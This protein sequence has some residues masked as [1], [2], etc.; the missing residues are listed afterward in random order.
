MVPEY[1]CCGPNILSADGEYRS[2]FTSVRMLQYINIHFKSLMEETEEYLQSKTKLKF[3]QQYYL[4]PNSDGDLF[5]NIIKNSRLNIQLFVVSWLVNGILMFQNLQSKNIHT[6]YQLTMY[7]NKDNE[8]MGYLFKTYSKNVMRDVYTV[9]TLS[10]SSQTNQKSVSDILNSNIRL[11]QKIIPL[12]KDGVDTLNIQYNTWR[13]IYI[14]MLCNDLLANII[15]PGVPLLYNWIIINGV[16]KYIFNNPDIKKQMVLENEEYMNSEYLTN[17]SNIINK[18]DKAVMVLTEYTGRTVNDIKLLVDSDE[19][20]S[21]VGNMFKNSVSFKKY[22]F[23]IVYTLLCLHQKLNI[24][25]GDL[26]L[27]NVTIRHTYKNYLKNVKSGNGKNI[28][29]VDDNIYEFDTM[30]FDGTVIDFSRSF[31]ISSNPK[32]QEEQIEKIL[33]Y[34]LTLF[35][36]FYKKYEKELKLKL[37][38][39]FMSV[40]M[41]FASIDLYIHTKCLLQFISNNKKLNTTKL[42]LQLVLDLNSLSIK[43]LTVDIIQVLSGKKIHSYKC[44]EF[45]KYFKN[46]KSDE[47]VENIYNFNNELTYSYNS[48]NKLPIMLKYLKMK[49]H[50]DDTEIFMPLR[51]DV[52]QDKLNVHF[53]NKNNYIITA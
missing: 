18:S 41:I 1:I 3:Y 27:N 40:Y 31:L 38:N 15:C 8:F 49:K 2:N 19:Y 23:D 43:H 28:F 45:L 42:N 46:C 17:R 16:D 5:K 36:D 6:D 30:G 34:Y 21:S 50:G 14:G 12:N 10:H 52:H 29:I 7:D 53:I 39:D 51:N 24:I 37:V 22:I 20:I 33:H 11:G 4:L 35:P 9:A 47:T 44:K 32:L 13:E 48:Y 26:H 25:H